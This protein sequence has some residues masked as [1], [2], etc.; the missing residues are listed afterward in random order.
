MKKKLLALAL[1][2]ALVLSAGSS[3]AFAYAFPGTSTSKSDDVRYFDM[4]AAEYIDRFNA[5]YG[6]MGLTLLADQSHD[7][8]WLAVNGDRTDI[9]VQFSDKINGPV[10]TGS[11]LDM[12]E[13]NWL[14]A[15]ITTSDYAVDTQYFA[16][17][18]MLC[19]QF[20]AVLGCEFTQ[21][22]FIDHCT[23]YGSDYPRMQYTK[24]GL[25]NEIRFRDSSVGDYHQT[26]YSVSIQLLQD[27]PEAEAKESEKKEASDEKTLAAADFSTEQITLPS[28]SEAQTYAEAEKLLAAG[29]IA[30]AAMTFGK[31]TG[32]KD[33]WKR[34]SELWDGI[35]QRDTIAAGNCH[36]VG[37][38]EDGTVVAAGPAYGLFDNCG[39][40]EVSDWK[41][42]I[43]VSAGAFHSVGLRVD[44]TVIATQYSGDPKNYHGQ[45]EVSSWTDIV[46]IAAGSCHTV[47]LRADG[48][49]VSTQYTGDESFYFHGQTNVSGWT[50]IVAVFA[51]GSHT[52]GLK[53]NGTVIATQYTGNQ[54]DNHGQCDVSGWKDVVAIATGGY[55]T[56]GLKLDGTVIATQ[57]KGN[58]NFNCNQCDV[59]DWRDIVNIGAGARFTVGVRG[60]GSVV[61]SGPEYGSYY[62]I[63]T[64][65]LSNWNEVVT[66]SA[67]WGHV[68]GLK[69]NGT[70]VALG[71][72]SSG[73]CNVSDWSNIKLPTAH[74]WKPILSPFSALTPT[75]TPAGSFN[76]T[77]LQ[78]EPGYIYDKFDDYWTWYA[79][80]DEAY[81]DA[82]LL[83]GIQLE[84]EVGGSDLAGVTLYTKIRN[85]DNRVIDG[86]QSIA[87]LV[88]GVKYS[89]P[90]M[91]GEDGAM[92]GSVVL[93][94]NGY[95]LIKA[96]ANAKEVSVKLKLF[97]G[98]TILL[99]LDSAQFDRT[100]GNMCRKIIQYKVWDYYIENPAVE[101]LEVMFPMEIT[102]K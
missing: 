41:H 96:F 81:T 1:V 5:K 42:I 95:E 91:P 9:R 77:I 98:G 46:A 43:A 87:F 80:Y 12:Q 75:T 50:E 69:V 88:D 90:E 68:V 17:L 22:E 56:V 53:A 89:F 35:T 82:N 73:Q 49:V 51:K 23:T 3:S 93:Y 13:W 83:I 21:E 54:Q 33:A 25:E 19:S 78:N 58:S 2:L 4:T 102:K 39:Q 8:C 14:Y 20:A 55:H 74:T 92:A 6:S 70:V 45:C 10:T 26:A 16:S 99:D 97:S 71:E 94:K 29:D 85:K 61:G 48:T 100:L 76:Y 47:G 28:S 67:G 59:S 72:N 18:P 84:G 32:Y 15:Y 62:N 27:T 64:P 86:V 37:V 57:Y 65:N 101:M 52:I 31:I 44:G 36:T 24:G 79:A 34:S 11:G 30:H 60:D 40:C 38:K 66:V 7:N 63:P